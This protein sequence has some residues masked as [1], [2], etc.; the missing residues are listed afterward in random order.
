MSVKTVYIC[1]RCGIEQDTPTQF[2]KV[3]VFV[4]SYQ[5]SKPKSQWEPGRHE[6]DWCRKC[7]EDMHLLPKPKDEARELPK[8]P[9]IEE[10]VVDIASEAAREALRNQQ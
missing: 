4:D 8:A 2:W 7:V 6:V 5:Y 10:L 1:D 9:T 3:K